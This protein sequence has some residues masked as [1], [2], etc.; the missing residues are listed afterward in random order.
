MKIKISQE[1]KIPVTPGRV[2]L[3]FEDLNY[4]LDGGLSAEMIENRNFEAKD[5]H[6]EWDQYIVDE[7]CAYGWTA[8]PQ[9]SEVKLKISSDRP[10]FAENPHYLRL[11]ASAPGTGVKN[12]AYDGIYLTSGMKYKISF[13]ARSYD[14]KGKIIVGVY[15]HGET[16]LE[17][18]IKIKP[19]GK[20]HAFSFRVKSKVNAEGADFVLAL[21][22]AGSVH[23]DYVS[24]LPENAIKGIFRRDLAEL[25]KELK[26]GFLRF[27]G[28]CVVEG[29]NLSNRYLWKES[30]GPRERRRHNWNRWAVHATGPENRFRSPFSHYGQTLDVGYYEFFLLCEY[31]GAK[32]LPVLSVGIACQY[33]STEFVPLEDPELESYLQDALDLIEFANGGEETEWGRLRVELGH[34][35]PFGLEYLGVGNEQWQTEDRESDG[36]KPA[37]KGNRFYERFELFERRIHEK[38]PQ[39]KIIGTVGPTVETPTY[40]SA[41]KW[42]RE[43]LARNENFVYASDEHFYVPPEWLYSHV[44]MYDAYPREGKV[45]AGEYAAHVPGSGAAF[46]NAP[47]ANCWEGALAEA[48]FM[49]G[50]EQN[51]DV[52]VMSS[53]APLFARLGYT[54]WS[55]SL[56]WFDGKSACPSANYYVQKLYSLYTGNFVLKTEAEAG[57]Y[58]SASEREG[59]TFVKV[60][61]A[62]DAPVEAEIEGDFDFGGMTRILRIEAGLGE[63]NTVDEPHRIVPTEIA[64][65][66]ARAVTLPPRSFSLLIFRRN[67]LPKREKS[68]KKE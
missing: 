39:I 1:G 32:P 17:K 25:M 36:E 33:M 23:L 47:Q 49:T 45:Y 62:G 37:Q 24:M 56:I 41:W 2:G 61:N 38:Y 31:L 4:A 18:R 52:V 28:G 60:V 19:D 64:P 46:F 53:Y 65:V 16:C 44:H 34:P 12:K 63:Y 30:L 14:F 43:N 40:E 58:A 55:P 13:Y 54:Q 51:S 6:G 20:W 29:N 8:Y 42:V 21:S 3:F 67:N 15:R 35:E 10:L 22:G 50:M 48:A 66:S 68:G 7:D 59:L 57:I 26:P 5:V 11:T 27:P 9:G